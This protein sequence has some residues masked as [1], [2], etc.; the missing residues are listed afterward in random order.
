[1]MGNSYDKP[2]VGAKQCAVVE[3]D[4]IQQ[5]AEAITRYAGSTGRTDGRAKE[6]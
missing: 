4:R 6:D 2:P 1:M 3:S 5:L